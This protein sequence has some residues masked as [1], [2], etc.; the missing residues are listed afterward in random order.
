MYKV[1]IKTSFAAAHRLREY[2]GA[3]ENLHGHNWSV[4]AQVSAGQLDHLGIAYDFKQLKQDVKSIVDRL[5]HQML[6]DI[7]PF[8]QINPT[9]ENVAKFIF[10]S[11]QT[12]LP[13]HLK[14]VSVAVGES[15]NYTA[16]YEA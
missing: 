2:E 5:D 13:P 14:V 9:S 3:C 12:K 1:S 10:D 7:D 4:I 6:N 15:E 16:T 11:L 8:T